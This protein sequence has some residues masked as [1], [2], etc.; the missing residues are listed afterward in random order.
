[1]SSDPIV[2]LSAAR[3]PVG[4]YLGNLSPKSAVELGSTAIRAAV[5]RAGIEPSSVDEAYIG[6]VLPAG[7]GQAPARQAALG[8][9]LPRSVASVTVNKV[10]GSGMQAIRYAFDALSNDSASLVVA[11]GME[12]MSNA[13]YLALKAR[14]GY[15]SGHGSF[16]DHVALD[17]L[18]DAYERG[19]PMG[20]FGEQ[21]ASHYA[22]T[23]ELQ[24]AFATESLLRAQR[25]QAESRFDWEIAPVELSTRQG[26]VSIAA[27]EQPQSVDPAKIPKL[28]PSFSPTG[29]ITPASSSPLS[30]GAAALVLTRESVAR[31]LGRQPIARIH[32]HCA[33]AQD[34]EW[35][36]TAPIGAL[37]KLF[38]RTGWQPREVDYYEVNEAFAVVPM[39][40]MHDFDIPR[41][42]M[43]AHGGACAIGHP[44]GASGARIVVTLLGVLRA[45]GAKRG[46]ASLCIGGGEATAVAVELL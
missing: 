40:V 24:D 35:F 3:T 33:H 5:E 28:K 37:K 1:M 44:I 25:S 20:E 2:I 43:N 14:G 41:E 23:R 15:R 6:C 7:L 21:C 29:T 30:D 10:C 36:T 38:A 8:A 19:R 31:R 18:E 13:P 22:F 45:Q 11:G 12:S 4:R 32:A 42:R 17:G 34:P 9:G 39:A 27:D 26:S 46:V 16:Y